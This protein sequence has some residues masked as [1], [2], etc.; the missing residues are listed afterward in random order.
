MIMG[1]DSEISSGYSF[2]NQFEY[3]LETWLKDRPENVDVIYY[4]G[5]KYLETKHDDLDSGVGVLHLACEDDLQSTFKKTWM[6]LQW[7]SA[8]KDGY[9]WIF[10]TNT[11]TFVNLHL[12]NEIIDTLDKTCL[13]GSDIY[14]L[15]ESYAPY[16]LSLYARGNGM[17]LSKEKV[18]DIVKEGISLMY[19]N[20]TDDVAI[21]N[22]IN[23]S[24]IK[25]NTTDVPYYKKVKGLTHGWYHCVDMNFDCGHSLSGYGDNATDI[26]HWE[27]FVTIQLKMYRQRENE[28]ANWKRFIDEVYTRM[29][30]SDYD[31]DK[32]MSYSDNP[33][34]FIG[35]II[36]YISY[37]EW[38]STDKNELYLHEISHKAS[39]DAEHNRFKEIQGM[40]I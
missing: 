5:G 38:V 17:L 4:D 27:R 28:K 39:D 10:R 2:Y 14:S 35:S 30:K 13:Y 18:N 6:A 16:P 1:A 21:G 25:N 36:G 3:S 9:D 7:V 37:D 26:N 32:I 29:K 11:S 12:L 33:S 31:I 20:L 15:S 23:S 40:K 8:N 22:C 34:V 24:Y 19:M